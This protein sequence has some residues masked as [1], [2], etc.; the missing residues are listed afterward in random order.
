MGFPYVDPNKL[1]LDP[2][3]GAIQGRS[4]DAGPT[5]PNLGVSATSFSPSE[6]QKL[7]AAL[8]ALE[9]AWLRERLD[10]RE[11]EVLGLPADYEETEL[12]EF[13]L[14]QLARVRALY[15][16]ATKAG[17]HVVVVMS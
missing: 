5:I 15:N 4:D 1:S 6:V 7:A 11:M 17:Q 9:D 3:L 8:N 14:P 10:V 16:R 12:D 2:A 13:Y